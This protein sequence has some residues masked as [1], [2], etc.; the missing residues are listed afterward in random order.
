MNRPRSQF[1]LNVKLA[2]AILPPIVSV[3]DLMGFLRTDNLYR[4][5]CLQTR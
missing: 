4:D 1:V 5:F 2:V 3:P